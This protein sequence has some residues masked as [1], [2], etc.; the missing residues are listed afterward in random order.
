LKT[1][2]SALGKVDEPPS[3]AKSALFEAAKNGDANLYAVFGGQGAANLLCLKDLSYIYTI[4]GSVLDDLIDI[5]ARTLERLTSSPKVS[6]YFEKSG[7]NI[8]Q[9]LF[10]SA[11]MPTPAQ[12]AEAPLSF[13]IIGLLSLAHHCI[14]CKSLGKHPGQLRGALRGVTGHSQGIIVAAGIA[15]SGSWKEFYESVVWVLETLF[16]I[17]FESHAAANG[18]PLPPADAKDSIRSGEGQPSSMLGVRGLD[19]RA[20]QILIDETNGQASKKD[21]IHLALI[22]SRDNM[23]VSGLPRS[24]RGLNLRLRKFKVDENDQNLVI[25]HRFL[26]ISAPFHSPLL[27]DAA[28]RVL[29]ALDSSTFSCG[30]LAIGLHHTHTGEDLR[31]NQPKDIMRRLVLMVMTEMVDWPKAS[32][33]PKATHILDFGPGRIGLLQG[34]VTEGTGVRVIIASDLR[35]VQA[36]IGSKEELF[37]STL[38]PLAVNWE[39]IYGPK[40]VQS[41]DGKVQLQTRMSKP[42]STSPIIVATKSLPWELIPALIK[43]GYQAELNCA[44]Y[45]TREDLEEA[46]QRVALNMAAQRGITCSFADSSASGWQISLAR[47]LIRKGLP[48]E[49]MTFG[50]EIPS[51]ESLKECIEDFGLTCISFKPSSQQSI[52]EIVKIAKMYP[53]FT[54]GL[55]WDGRRT[56]SQP[57]ESSRDPMLRIYSQVRKCLNILLIANHPFGGPDDVYPYLTGEWSEGLGYARMPFDGVNMEDQIMTSKESNTSAAVTDRIRQAEATSA[58]ESHE[59]EDTTTGGEIIEIRLLNGEARYATATRAALL[60]KHLDTTIFSIRDPSKRLAELERIRAYLIDRLNTDFQKP[61]FG[62]DFTGNNVDIS[63]M[64]YLEVL[65]RSISLMYIRKQG[66]WIDQSYETFVLDFANRVQD[67]LV[68]FSSFESK[69]HIQDSSQFLAEFVDCYP[70]AAEEQMSPADVTY[71]LSL[72][73]RGGQKPV[74]FIPRLD[75]NFETW[76]KDDAFLQAKDI[77]AFE[78]QDVQRMIFIQETVATRHLSAVDESCKIIL[79]GIMNSWVER[80]QRDLDLNSAGASST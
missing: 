13:P 24:L 52:L 25:Q 60:W 42:M 64:T 68:M 12:V 15:R 59:P 6:S 54:F 23:V 37:S 5:A 65:H 55:H 35:A 73:S 38:P 39:Q 10:N 62:V 8:R 45:H 36:G 57:F 66:K 61:W 72:C 40:L 51:S 4:Y 58:N 20:L 67:N 14:T 32:H 30:Q 29:E 41:S 75:E 48:I 17:G 21:C 43:A 53:S 28:E 7:F 49:G 56:G 70:A 33:F 1:Y 44:D 50:A 22:N 16:W 31:N 2:Y 77:E 69:E 34:Q 47:E 78:D 26:P 79:D 11:S 46:I 9:W 71:F 27:E 3:P 74:N 19:Q 63:E 80:L 18:F 76:F